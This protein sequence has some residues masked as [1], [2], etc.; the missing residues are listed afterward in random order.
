MLDEEHDPLI[1]E[2]YDD[3]YY[4]YGSI[5][6]HNVVIARMSQGQPGKVS[7]SKLVQPLSPSLSL[8]T[9]ETDSGPFPR[10]K[11]RNLTAETR[12]RV[13]GVTILN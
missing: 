11:V 5:N 9:R 7:A 2:S 3:S 1:L 8:L 10:G 6:G 12:G 13:Y 4:T